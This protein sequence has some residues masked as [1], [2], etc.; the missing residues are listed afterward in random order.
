MT[1]F[2]KEKK[3]LERYLGEDVLELLRVSNAII[4]G[5][6]ITSI[7][8]HKEINDIDV[9]FRS[10]ED[11]DVFIKNAYAKGDELPDA[12]F[13]DIP[14]FSAICN[15]HTS[16]SVLFMAGDVKIQ[17]IHFNFFDKIQGI[18]DSFDF[19][20]N[21][22]AYDCATG[23]FTLGDRFLVDLSKRRLEFNPKT[24][25]PIISTL[26]VS[27]YTSRGFNISKKSMFQLALA[28]QNLTINTWEELEDQL[29]G[30]YGVD[31]SELFDKTAEFSIPDAIDMLDKVEEDFDHEVELTHPTYAQLRSQLREYHNEE[32]PKRFYKKVNY[33]NG[34]ITSI[35]YKNFE[36]DVSELVNG[37]VN[38]LWAFET[39][40]E[41]ENYPHDGNAILEFEL[42]GN[43]TV[44]YRYDNEVNILGDVEVIAL[45]LLADKKKTKGAPAPV[46]MPPS[47]A[48]CN[49]NHL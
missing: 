2:L 20:I 15:S 11:L 6:A 27:K 9:Y 18:F 42:A 25:Y 22:G 8:S 37:G 36:W 39:K 1:V 47:A 35:I 3:A 31:V 48:P 43:N 16:R 49:Y 23:E 5:G 44:E 4:A 24:T 29:S 41:A 14:E 34:K 45:R 33:K 38:G 40:E 26:R 19:T 10:F 30:F 12:R 46:A 7:F 28:V 21:M 13:A 17:L 32:Q